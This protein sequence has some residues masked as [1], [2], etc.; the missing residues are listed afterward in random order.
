MRCGWRGRAGGGRAHSPE[1]IYR[2]LEDAAEGGGSVGG[3]QQ[4]NRSKTV[5]SATPHSFL[6]LADLSPLLTL[7]VYLLSSRPAS[8]PPDSLQASDC[9]SAAAANAL[10]APAERTAGPMPRCTFSSR[11]TT[12]HAALRQRWRH[13]HPRRITP[14][15]SALAALLVAHEVIP[16]RERPVSEPHLCPVNPRPPLI[17]PATSCHESDRS[18]FISRA[19]LVSHVCSI[20]RRR[21][22]H[23][24]RVCRASEITNL[25]KRAFRYRPGPIPPNAT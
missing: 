15:A 22:V 11:L 14:W 19:K 17:P 20:Q 21:T 5:F 24:P 7:G 18:P 10:H 2:G 25:P 3:L 1:L 8:S 13:R 4:T 23:D 16:A 6:S 12:V 9:S